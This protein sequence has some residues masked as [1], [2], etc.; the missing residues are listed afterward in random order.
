MN[1][2]SMGDKNVSKHVTEGRNIKTTTELPWW[3]SGK[4]SAKAGHTGS[5]PSL[6]RSHILWSN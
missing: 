5:I 3:L 6:G 1:E 2:Q 4:G